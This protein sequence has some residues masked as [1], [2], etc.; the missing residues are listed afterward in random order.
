MNFINY[1]LLI[2]RSGSNPYVKP[3]G[4]SIDPDINE[5]FTLKSIFD[6]AYQTY[7]LWSIKH[8]GIYTHGLINT[9]IV[10]SV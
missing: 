1:K 2:V 3:I 10:T 8:S 7:D 4:H 5:G 6:I 9:S